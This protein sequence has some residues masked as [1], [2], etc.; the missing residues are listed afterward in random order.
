M[1]RRF[2]SESRDDGIKQLRMENEKQRM[3]NG[4]SNKN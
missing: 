4:L 2:L 1:T 3:E